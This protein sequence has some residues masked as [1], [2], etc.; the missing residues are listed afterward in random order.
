MK[1][2]TPGNQ[3]AGE[4]V[5]RDNLWAMETPQIFRA[6]LLI[7]AYQ[8]ILETGETVTDE[9]SALQALGREVR[10]VENPH[11]NPKITVPADLQLAAGLA[12]Q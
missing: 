2:A 4:S 3:T 9:A 10:L 5:A 6:R 11:P 7:E 8:K 1:R 12:D